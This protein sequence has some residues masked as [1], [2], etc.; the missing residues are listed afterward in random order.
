MLTFVFMFISGAVNRWNVL[1]VV[2]VVLVFC[3]SDGEMAGLVSGVVAADDEVDADE[4]GE[5]ACSCACLL[6]PGHSGSA[7]SLRLLAFAALR[8]ATHCSR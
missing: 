2:V 8:S 7:S 6:A 3:W 5:C 1:V 4:G